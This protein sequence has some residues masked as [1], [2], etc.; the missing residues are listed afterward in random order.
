M[1]GELLSSFFYF[2]LAV[3]SCLCHMLLF[4]WSFFCFCSP[5]FPCSFRPF[6]IFHLLLSAPFFVFWRVAFS[7]FCFLVEIVLFSNMIPALAH[8]C[9][10][11]LNDEWMEWMVFSCVAW[12]VVGGD[13]F[14]QVIE[15]CGLYD[16]RKTTLRK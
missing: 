10:D 6:V 9:C 16:E 4:Y 7:F 5:V 1:E 2:F 13:E 15:N 14:Y 11:G 12:R 8:V 3:F